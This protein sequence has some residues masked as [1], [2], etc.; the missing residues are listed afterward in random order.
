METESN[1][2]ST[3]KDIV[4]Y[5]RKVPAFGKTY[6]VKRFAIGQ[7]ARAAEYIAPLGYLLRSA[8]EGDTIDLLVKSLSMGGEP[9]MGLLAVVTEE[10]VEWLEEQDPIE[11]LELLTATVEANAHYFFDSANLERIKALG[12]RIEVVIETYGPKSSVGTESSVV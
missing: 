1:E 9:A 4:N 8:V 11:G 7:L 3:L 5:P 12:K 10:P 6:E 2:N